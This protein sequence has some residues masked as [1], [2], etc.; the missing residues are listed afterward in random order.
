M[1]EWRMMFGHIQVNNRSGGDQPFGVDDEFK[2]L[3]DLQVESERDWREVGAV[4]PVKHQGMCKSCWTF[5][6]IGAIESDY[7]IKHAKLYNFSEQQ[8]LDCVHSQYCQGCNGGHFAY[9]WMYALDH[10][11]GVAFEKD[12]PYTGNGSEA[13][14]NSTPNVASIKGYNWVESN[15]TLLKKRI[16]YKPVAV[17]I[18][19]ENDRFRHYAGGVITKGCGTN[20]DHAVLAVGYG[21]TPEGQ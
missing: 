3:E 14:K 5:A 8:V 15:P 1:E 6:A 4:T 18:E 13:C 19:G 7:A 2:D 17:A 9:A 16:Y 20:V 12:Y 21:E 10:N 11:L